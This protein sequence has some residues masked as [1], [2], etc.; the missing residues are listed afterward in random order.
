MEI[1][2]LEDWMEWVDWVDWRDRIAQGNKIEVAICVYNSE[3]HL[4]HVGQTCS[5]GAGELNIDSSMETQSKNTQYIIYC[6]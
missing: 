6:I 1:G 4:L 2:G 3:K 5:V